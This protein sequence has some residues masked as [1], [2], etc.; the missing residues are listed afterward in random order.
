M[1]ECKDYYCLNSHG[2]IEDG[3]KKKSERKSF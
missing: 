2:M 1:N 3:L